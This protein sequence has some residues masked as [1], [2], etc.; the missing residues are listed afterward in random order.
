MWRRYFSQALQEALDQ[1]KTRNK[2]I[3]LRAY[4]RIIGVTP[5]NLSEILREQRKIAPER[6][7]KIAENAKLDPTVLSRLRRLMGRE[8]DPSPPRLLS[9]Q[10]VDLIMNPLYFRVLCA[11]EILPS[12][13][14]VAEL[15]SFLDVPAADLKKVLTALV[16]VDVIEIKGQKVHWL[17]SHVITPP[18]VPSKKVRAFH[19]QTLRNAA[20]DLKLPVTEREYTSVVFAA[21][22]SQLG[23]A[24]QQIRSFRDLVSESMRDSTPDR[25]YELSIQLRPVSKTFP[26]KK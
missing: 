23:A 22:E 17:G 26:V 21:C 18:D 25:I 13:S 20:A 3:S 9:T 14:T 16:A 1:A 6:A 11:L 2:A 12:P 19:R 5:S 4:A 8:A 10:A 24:K 15:S 7:L